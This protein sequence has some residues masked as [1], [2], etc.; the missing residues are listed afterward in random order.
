MLQCL[1]TWFPSHI[2]E[3]AVGPSW[4]GLRCSETHSLGSRHL[5]VSAFFCE[6]TMQRGVP[7]VWMRMRIFYTVFLHRSHNV[8]AI[9]SLIFFFAVLGLTLATYFQSFRF[10]IFKVLPSP[11]ISIVASLSI[12]FKNPQLRGSVSDPHNPTP[13]ALSQLLPGH[14]HIN[15]KPTVMNVIILGCD[16][17]L[18]IPRKW[19]IIHIFETH[20]FRG[21]H[22]PLPIGWLSRGFRWP[23]FVPPSV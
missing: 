13:R 7:A 3:G 14:R 17:S 9:F 2:S 10:F 23:H 18:F 8:E 16:F 22:S 5:A 4:R 1:F 20:N 15:D 6:P 12:L 21:Y 11:S 19:F